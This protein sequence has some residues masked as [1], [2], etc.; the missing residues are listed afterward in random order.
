MRKNIT[1]SIE[2][3]ALLENNCKRIEISEL[4]LKKLELKIFIKKLKLKQDAF[5][6]ELD[7]TTSIE[8]LDSKP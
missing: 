1:T 7:L 4:E 5:C 3:E 8:A 2:L 6:D